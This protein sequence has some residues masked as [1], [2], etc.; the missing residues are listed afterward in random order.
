VLVRDPAGKLSPRAYFSTRQADTP[1]AVVAEF[2]K[3]WTIETTFEEA[4]AHLGV[5]T[6]RQ[7]SETA[8]A[9]ETPCLLGLYSL[10]AVLAQ[11]LH[12]AGAIPVQATAWYRKGEPT[13]ADVLA[14]VR[15]HL[16]GASSY[17]TSGRDPD[18]LE[19]PRCELNRL[20]Q[21]VCYSH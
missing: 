5:E 14:D 15:R 19:I 16:W 9:R 3:R 4:R 10:V 1:R 21:A 11:A 17:A 12:P 18:L 7:W 13:F 2:I 8:L 6:Q 20:V